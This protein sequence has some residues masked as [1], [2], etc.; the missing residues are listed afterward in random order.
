M[1]SSLVRVTFDGGFG[2]DIGLIDH[3]N[4]LLVITLNYS[5]IADFHTSPNHTKYFPARSIFIS[6]C[7]VTASNNGY[8]SA[9]V[10]KPP[11]NSGSLP[12]AYSSESYF[13][14]GGLPP[15]RHGDKP[16]EAHDQ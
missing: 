1:I 12:T 9:S 2:F 8:S 5:A 13:T 3:F 4:T 10:L 16:L 7:L 11:L 15:V 14:T 6:S